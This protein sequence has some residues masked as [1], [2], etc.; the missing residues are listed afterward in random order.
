MGSPLEARILQWNLSHRCSVDRYPGISIRQCSV[1][2]GPIQS[3]PLSSIGWE[4]AGWCYS[5]GFMPF[6]SFRDMLDCGGLSLNWLRRELGLDCVFLYWRRWWG[7]VMEW[8]AHLWR[9][10]VC[11]SSCEAKISNMVIGVR[12][13]LYEKIKFL[14]FFF[15][16]KSWKVWCVVDCC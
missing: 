14:L 12:N 6:W 10:S 5:H 8:T 2:F 13:S 16:R 11:I 3:A 1:S 15:L 7:A 9:N 4:A